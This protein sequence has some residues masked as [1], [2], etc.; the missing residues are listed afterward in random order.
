MIV[1]SRIMPLD[2]NREYSVRDAAKCIGVAYDVILRYI[3]DGKL[4][5]TKVHTRGL[6]QEWRIRGKEIKRF[7]E[8]LGHSQ[9]NF[10]P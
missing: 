6:R 1:R 8:G 5:A 9:V 10:L 3:R 7:L 4:G 2:A